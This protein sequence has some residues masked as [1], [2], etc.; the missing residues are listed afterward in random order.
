MSTGNSS[1]EIKTRI[2]KGKMPL[3]KVKDKYSLEYT[4][5]VNR[6][7]GLLYY[8]LFVPHPGIARDGVNIKL[9]F[10]KLCQGTQWDP[11]MLLRALFDLNRLNIFASYEKNILSKRGSLHLSGECYIML[12]TPLVFF[13]YLDGSTAEKVATALPST[14]ELISKL[15]KAPGEIDLVAAGGETEDAKHVRKPER[16][17]AK[18]LKHLERRRPFGHKSVL[19]KRAT[20]KS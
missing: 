20:E 17:K 10:H 1:A 6:A 11:P 12:R 4:R 5:R 8:I 15:R 2:N 19:A 3:E 18:G 14:N 16:P 9:D 13:Q 7:L